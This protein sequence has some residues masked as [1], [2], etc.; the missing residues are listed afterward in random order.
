M[1]INTIL[2]RPPATGDEPQISG[3]L[4]SSADLRELTNGTPESNAEWLKL[5]SL[6]ELRSRILSNEKTLVATWNEIVVGFIAFKRGNHLS[7]LF[8]RREFSRQ[9]IGRQ[10]FMQCA[11]DL[12]EV[13]VNAAEE[14]VDFYQKV[15]FQPTGD[16]FYSY[17]IWQTPMQWTN[18]NIH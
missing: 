8:V 17:G 15:G 4:W 2:Y 5:C 1:N 6:A 13:T 12:N 9:G 11:K 14:A 16:R 18:P 7:L 3:C 10:L